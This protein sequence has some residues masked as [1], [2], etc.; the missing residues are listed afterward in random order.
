M[1]R[2]IDIS[3]Y[4][5]TYFHERFIRRA[6]ESVLS[7]ITNYTY[8]IVIS[9]DGSTDGTMD[10]LRE[11]QK[12]YPER[13]VVL[14]NEKN[15]G[16]PKNI[17]QARCNCRGKYIVHLDGDDYWIS[18][19]KL[20]IQASFLDQHP[21]FVAVCNRMELRYDNS[22]SPF[23]I[24]PKSKDSNVE[25]TIKDFERG[26]TLYNHGFMMRNVFL[27]SEGRQFFERAQSI[28]S[29][30]DDAVDCLL[31]LKY[32]RVFVLDK[33]T[34]AYVVF[35][36]KDNPYNYNSK[37]SGLTRFE[38]SIE[39]YSN[40]YNEFGDTVSFKRKYISLFSRLVFFCVKNKKNYIYK[41]FYKD[42]P[43]EYKRPF[44]AGVKFLSYI[45]CFMIMIKKVFSKGE[46]I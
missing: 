13:I 43:K 8:E 28:S 17:Y 42:V 20:E 16:I 1:D 14:H 19:E 36:K 41:E 2:N 34:D 33:V 30:V 26:K 15:I 37:Y 35:D 9:D 10:I 38:N 18:N 5:L 22:E 4:I 23:S 45:D 3:V 46:R 6:I 40:L 44:F 25:F 24:L 27:S 32:G 12:K 29:K 11:Y 21:E 31:L 39:L 7:Q